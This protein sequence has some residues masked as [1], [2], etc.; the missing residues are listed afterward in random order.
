MDDFKRANIVD[1]TSL[2]YNV[3]QY[4]KRSKGDGQRLRQ[5]ARSRLKKQ[6]KK[7]I[8]YENSN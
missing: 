1:V 2:D 4:V 7:D 8:K 6:L 3:P 5:L